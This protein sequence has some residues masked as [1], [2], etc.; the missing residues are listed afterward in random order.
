MH[1]GE[2]MT[3]A[4]FWMIISL[5]DWEYAGDDKAVVEPAIVA[6]SQLSESEIIGFS[7]TLAEKLYLL[8][9]KQ[10]AVQIG[11]EAY[12][13]DESYFS[14]DWFLYARCV[15]VANGKGL[16]ETVLADPREF[17][18]DLEFESLLYIADTAYERKTGRNLEH[19]TKYSYETYSNQSGW[20]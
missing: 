18:N 10:H 17:P 7:E 16:F 3:E 5:F 14:V 9:T 12:A 6:L 1:H 19:S 8:D 13:G 4:T 2:Y 15:V 11:E 20:K